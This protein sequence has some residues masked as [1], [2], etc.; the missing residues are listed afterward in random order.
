MR[1]ERTAR[2]W[3]PVPVRRTVRAG[4]FH[5]PYNP[6]RESLG[7]TGTADTAQIFLPRNVLMTDAPPRP[8]DG[9]TGMVH[10][11][12]ERYGPAVAA[13]PA[14]AVNGGLQS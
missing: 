9:V 10:P 5:N 6:F 4:L 11:V 1:T 12:S 13:L 7:T 8:D 14:A 2:D 3:S